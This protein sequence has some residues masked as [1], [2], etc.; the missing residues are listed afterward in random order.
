MILGLDT[1]TDY[2]SLAVEDQGKSLFDYQDKHGKR[3]GEIL[4][5]KVAELLSRHGIHSQ[6]LSG[7]ALGL[8]PGSFTGVRVGVAAALGL[9]QSLELPIM[10]ISSFKVIASALQAGKVLVVGDARRGLFYAAGYEF[11]P[12]GLM[13]F[14]QESLV[15][16][17]A[18]V[19]V[20]SSKDTVLTGPQAAEVYSL[21]QLPCP[22]LRLAPATYYWPQAL[23]LINLAKSSLASGGVP[24]TQIDPIYL[25]KTQAEEMREKKG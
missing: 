6:D 11:T 1:S 17:D 4:V 20:A 8:G 23:H 24:Y 9:A 22:N 10:G 2:L 15:D 3:H 13:P 16:L 5:P 14:L 19:R 21:L 25:R 7:I 12:S 18:L